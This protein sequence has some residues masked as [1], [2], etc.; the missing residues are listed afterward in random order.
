MM[1]YRDGLLLLKLLP[2]PTGFDQCLFFN[3]QPTMHCFQQTTNNA[4]KSAELKVSGSLQVKLS[5][6]SVA[7]SFDASLSLLGQTK[8]QIKECDC[9]NALTNGSLL[10]T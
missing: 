9:I 3:K 8:M 6:A 4:M 5:I 1:A 7:L 2:S 10:V